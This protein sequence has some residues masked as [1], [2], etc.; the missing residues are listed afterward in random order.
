MSD[1]IQELNKEIEIIKA[2]NK[3]VEAD[4]AWETSWG[5][6]LSISLITYITASAFLYF[7]GAK[8][9]LLNALVPT[10]GYF[11]STRSLPMI[12]KWWLKK[13]WQ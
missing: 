13:F 8:N 11:L 4:K 10:I 1:P 12:K 5:R 2:R 9:F 6:T 3:K 7:S